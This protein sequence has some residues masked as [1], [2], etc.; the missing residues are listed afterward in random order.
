MAAHLPDA[1]G[2]SAVERQ[3]QQAKREAAVLVV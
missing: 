2:L 1:D 3:D